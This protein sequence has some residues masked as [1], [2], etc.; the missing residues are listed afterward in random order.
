M[1]N[2]RHN[3]TSH[4][5]EYIEFVAAD[6]RDLSAISLKDIHQVLSSKFGE[7]WGVV[8]AEH[9]LH[10]KKEMKRLVVS[11]MSEQGKGKTN[12]TSEK[13]ASM[14]LGSLLSWPRRFGRDHPASGHATKA[15][16]DPIPSHEEP[17]DVRDRITA[18]FRS[19]CSHTRGTFVFSP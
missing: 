11:A 9:G 7:E 17:V 4:I 8:C 13:G 1:P 15:E 10:I 18:S 12:E 5:K 6:K 2:V 19:W 14:M 16:T 3:I